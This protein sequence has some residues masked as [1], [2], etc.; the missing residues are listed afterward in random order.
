MFPFE[1]L[2]DEVLVTNRVKWCAGRWLLQ[3]QG[4]LEDRC[5]QGRNTGSKSASDVYIGYLQF[6][7]HLRPWTH[8]PS[9][10]PDIKIT[11]IYV[12]YE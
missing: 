12:L 5:V 9:K 6:S 7:R 10:E 11:L 4:N 8:S 2:M 3:K 1:G